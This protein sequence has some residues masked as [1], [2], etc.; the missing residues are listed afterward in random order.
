MQSRRWVVW[1][2]MAVIAMATAPAGGQES[3]PD[4]EG[5]DK[6]REARKKDSKPPPSDKSAKKD[7]T[8]EKEETKKEE[9][10]KPGGLFGG[11]SSFLLI[12]IGGFILL[13]FLMSRG[14][15][16][17]AAKRKDMLAGLKKGDKITTIGGVVG[18]VMDVREDEV[19][20]KVDETNNIRV[21]FARWAVRGVGQEA[22][23]EK[24][25]DRK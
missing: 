7:D 17:Q 8:E 9:G 3:T 6:L 21:R 19:T 1:A 11:G 25:E 10:K 18:T 12:M 16:K 4:S 15:R 13:Y 20:V 2:W 23:T 22:K 14:R 5:A 24:P